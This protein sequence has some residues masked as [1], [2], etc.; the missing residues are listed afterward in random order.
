MIIREHK[1]MACYI[2]RTQEHNEINHMYDPGIL[3]S[4]HLTFRMISLFASSNSYNVLVDRMESNGMP[5]LR[6]KSRGFDSHS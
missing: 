1:V 3:T 6:S 2:K 5:N 4:I